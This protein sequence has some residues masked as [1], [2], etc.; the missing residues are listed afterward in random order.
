MNQ[1][2]GLR[3]LVILAILIPKKYFLV[4]CFIFV[5]TTKVYKCLPL[6]RRGLIAELMVCGGETVIPTI[7]T[8]AT[9]RPAVL[10]MH[11]RAISH[12]A[13]RLASRACIWTITQKGA[14][15]A[16]SL[17]LST[18]HVTLRALGITPIVQLRVARIHHKE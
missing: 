11:A 18:E 17:S 3:C 1:P 10:E 8:S 14:A 7:G 4:Q 9:I 16:M 6:F 13:A 12:K 2:R 5:R 15:S